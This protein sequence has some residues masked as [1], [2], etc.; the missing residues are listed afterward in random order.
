MKVFRCVTILIGKWFI[1]ASVFYLIKVLV[2][3]LQYAESLFKGVT[4]VDLII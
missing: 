1:Y 3:L 2:F 4:Y